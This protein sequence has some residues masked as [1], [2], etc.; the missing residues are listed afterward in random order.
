MISQQ[1]VLN[2]GD[3]RQLQ[4]MRIVLLHH[5]HANRGDNSYGKEF[6]FLN[7]LTLLSFP[8][9]NP[10]NMPKLIGWKPFSM[11][12]IRTWKKSEIS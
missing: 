7:S 9:L 10:H 6:R 3:V 1:A 4:E 5:T 2:K 12:R 8:L 11:Q